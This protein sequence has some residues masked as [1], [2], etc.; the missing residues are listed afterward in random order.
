MDKQ[1][2]Q[3]RYFT[4]YTGVSL[5][6]KLIDELDA[7]AIRQR[8]SYFTGYYDDAQRLRIIE[9]VVYGEIEFSHHY[10][11]DQHD[12][13]HKAILIEADSLPRTL[14]IDAK[15]RMHEAAN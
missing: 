1:P 14:L 5:P 2:L 3:C 7:P 6:L 12:Q 8:I 4:S 9:K 11:Y 15:G 10:E 13:L